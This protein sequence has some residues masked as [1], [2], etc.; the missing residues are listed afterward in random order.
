MKKLAEFLKILRPAKRVENKQ[1]DTAVADEE[2]FE[3]CV[4]CG[5]I[6][7][8]EKSTPIELRENYELGCGQLCH[9]CH[10]K[11]EK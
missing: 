9:L 11:L 6:T 3:R 2:R 1:V 5:S 8:T 7:T 4:L 10:M